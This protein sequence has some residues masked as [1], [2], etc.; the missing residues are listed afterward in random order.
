MNDNSSLQTPGEKLAALRVSAGRTLDDMAEATKIPLPMLQAIE[1]DEYHKISGDLYVKSF[2]RSYAAEVGLEAEEILDLYGNFT[3]TATR[4]LDPNAGADGH[5]VW[6]EEEIQIKRL[7][8]PWVTIGIAGALVV[9]AVIVGY[10]LLRGGGDNPVAEPVPALEEEFS[11]DSEENNSITKKDSVVIAETHESLLAGGPLADRKQPV[12]AEVET[13]VISEPVPSSLP[14][15]PAG[16]P[17]GLK[18]DD[19]TWP[20][21]LSLVCPE[22]REVAVKKDGDRQYGQV[23]WPAANRPLPDQGIQAGWAYHIKEGLVIFWGAEDHFS[24]KIDNPAGFRAEINGQY[25]DVSGLGLGAE[26]ILNDPDVIRSN[27][28]S[29]NRP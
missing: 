15:Q 18:I 17:G 19:R 22:S 11:S 6:Q 1:Q 28:P 8:L 10:F 9:L 3:G 20:V 7:G 29:A 13:P 24:L 26:L 12:E 2:L 23:D 21:V 16:Q 14:E 5:A 27:L 4:P 25:R